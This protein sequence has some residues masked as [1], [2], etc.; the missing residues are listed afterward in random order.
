MLHFF[1][2]ADTVVEVDVYKRT[3]SV[4]PCCSGNILNSVS[5]I[6]FLDGLGH[7]YDNLLAVLDVELSGEECNVE[8]D[9][10]IV[11]TGAVVADDSRHTSF[12]VAA[13]AR[14]IDDHVSG[15]ALLYNVC[16]VTS[17]KRSYWR[18]CFLEGYFLPL[19]CQLSG[20]VL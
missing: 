19:C 16:L 2:C 13:V 14:A 12:L 8:E 10:D 11:D 20:F 17:G 1:R 15:A 7:R 3:S 4:L 6:S 18:T 9:L 5:C